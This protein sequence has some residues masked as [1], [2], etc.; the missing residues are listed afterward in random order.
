MMGTTKEKTVVFEDAAYALRTAKTEGLITC[1]IYDF[2][3]K[4]PEKVRELSDIFLESYAD[5]SAF[6][7][8]VQSV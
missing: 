8:F 4:E 7:A 2:H 3:C 5:T 1:G 6:W